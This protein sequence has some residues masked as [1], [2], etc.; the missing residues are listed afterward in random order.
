MLDFR[1]AL[2][3]ILALYGLDAVRRNR[4]PPPIHIGHPDFRRTGGR[5]AS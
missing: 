3:A 1:S 4:R 2:Q 5:S